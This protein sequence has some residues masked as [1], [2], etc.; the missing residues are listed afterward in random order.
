MFTGLILVFI[1]K[2]NHM[3]RYAILSKAT[4]SD[5]PMN[6]IERFHITAN[7]RIL[8]QY[9]NRDMLT[10]SDGNSVQMG[11]NVIV[12]IRGT[13]K[14][15]VKGSLMRDLI[16]NY[17]IAINKN[18]R[19]PRI[20]EVEKVINQIIHAGVQKNKIIL[21][22]HSLGAYVAAKISKDMGIR[23]IVFNIASSIA[24]DRTDK[25]H[26]LTHYTTNN[27]YRGIIDPLSITSVLRDDYD[28][29]IVKR[30]YDTNTHSIENFIPV[31]LV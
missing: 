10:V 16:N 8:P 20:I 6:T 23:A 3:E 25:N 5:N 11:R 26:L 4:Y 9:S 15:N 2:P 19:I 21:T 22:G 13:D 30:K 17:S 28:T 24:D 14:K 27:F 18:E 29:Y 7:L 1:F 31:G 12:A